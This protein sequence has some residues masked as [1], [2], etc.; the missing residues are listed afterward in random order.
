MTWRALSARPYLGEL[1][2][3]A[4]GRKG[5]LRDRREG[6]CCECQQQGEEREREGERPAV[7]GGA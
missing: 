3:G 4:D 6:E 5:G 7:L 1:G 2:E